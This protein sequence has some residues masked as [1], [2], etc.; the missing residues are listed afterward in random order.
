MQLRSPGDK[1]IEIRTVEIEQWIFG[2]SRGVPRVVPTRPGMVVADDRIGPKTLA[3]LFAL[4]GVG[5]VHGRRGRGSYSSSFSLALGEFGKSQE[6][7]PGS[8]ATSSPCHSAKSLCR[9]RKASTAD[10]TPSTSCP[11]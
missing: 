7:R 11:R 3:P 5:F 4:F 6:G 8:E 10:G 1:C 2:E 9:A